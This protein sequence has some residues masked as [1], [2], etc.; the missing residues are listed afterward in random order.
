MEFPRSVEASD[1]GRCAAVALERGGPAE[2]AGIKAGD[3]IVAVNG[4]AVESSGDLPPMIAEIEPG[5]KAT[6]TLWRDKSRKEISIKVAELQD[7]KVA[8][9][10]DV[11]GSEEGKLGLAVRPLNPT[12]RKEAQTEGRLVVEDVQ[13]PAAM[14]GVMPGDI[15]LAV[16]GRPVDTVKGL[17][18]AVEASGSTVA[19]LIQRGE[20]QIYVPVRVG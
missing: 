6:L 2:D 18:D 5:T 8:A 7:E 9:T 3:V 12:E 1:I 15:I 13:G 19:L 14:A 20:A 10:E 11:A 4:Q 17:R 16:N